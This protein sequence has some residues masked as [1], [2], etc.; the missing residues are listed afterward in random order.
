MGPRAP[1]TWVLSPMNQVLSRLSPKGSGREGGP[2]LG[3]ST[4]TRTLELAPSLVTRLRGHLALSCSQQRWGGRQ[5]LLVLLC[6]GLP[7]GLRRLCCI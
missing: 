6:L 5:S 2:V 7:T 4:H 1:R 3:S